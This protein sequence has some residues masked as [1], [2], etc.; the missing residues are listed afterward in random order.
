MYTLVCN[1]KLATT[2]THTHT[3]PG[4]VMFSVGAIVALSM[5]GRSTQNKT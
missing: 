5:L 4:L 1:I 2:H 3:L